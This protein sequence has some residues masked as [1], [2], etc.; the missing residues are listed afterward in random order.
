MYEIGCQL[1]FYYASM[2]L[3]T[4]PIA[5]YDTLANLTLLYDNDKERLIVIVV[6]IQTTSSGAA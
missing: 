3:S 6:K 2:S 5:L 1:I 4:S